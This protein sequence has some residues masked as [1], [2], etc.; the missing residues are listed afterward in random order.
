MR[1]IPTVLY[2]TGSTVAQ[3]WPSVPSL[4]LFQSYIIDEITEQQSKSAVYFSH[5]VACEIS[6]VKSLTT[7]V[8]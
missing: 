8:N 5:P 4:T 3:F 1:L 6:F 2:C 7:D